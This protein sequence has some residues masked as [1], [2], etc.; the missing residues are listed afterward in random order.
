[1]G[2]SQ[3]VST[4]FDMKSLNKNIT[5]QITNNSQSVSASQNNVEELKLNLKNIK[6]CA[7]NATQKIDAK[8]NSSGT[9]MAST[10]VNY[11]TQISTQLKAAAKSSIDSA[12]G[13][14]ATAI[15]N[16]Q[17]TN[18]KINETIDNV[19]EKNI[20]TNNMQKIASSAVNVEKGTLTIDGYECPPV[21]IGQGYPSINFNQDLTSAVVAQG[22]TTALTKAL[23][24]DAT[25]SS[26]SSQADSA[27]KSVATG[28]LQDL[29]TAVSGIFGSLT[30]PFMI[31]GVV[32]CVICAAV[33]AFMLSPAGQNATGTVSKAAANKL[34]NIP[35]I[36][37]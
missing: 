12:T 23:T 27:D 25:I 24:D 14:L 35:I 7:F 2:N 18:T 17:K 15:G 4:A 31:S 6:G 21:A 30:M 29:G 32:L 13:A 33:L 16:K 26:I 1:M 11:K 5:N 8:T 20:T 22:V 10:I 34:K 28:P 36:P 9:Q 3:S 19:V 37:V